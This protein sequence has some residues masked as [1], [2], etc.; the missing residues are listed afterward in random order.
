MPTTRTRPTELVIF[1]Q[2]FDLLNWLFPQCER[3]PKTQRFVVTQRL[4]GA[5]LDFQEALF[6][7]NARSGEARFQ[8]LQ[9]A[10]AAVGLAQRGAVRA[11]QPHG[12]GHRQAAGRLAAADETRRRRQRHVGRAGRG[13]ADRWIWPHP[14]SSMRP[15]RMAPCGTTLP[16]PWR[17]GWRADQTCLAL[18]FFLRLGG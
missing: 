2:T 5:A 9:A 15:S 12:G 16:V 6:D 17:A 13:A 8:Q 11:C 10:G 4:Q 7:A 1:T 14:G 18:F 3:F